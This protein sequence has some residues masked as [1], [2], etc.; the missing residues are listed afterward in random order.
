MFAQGKLPDISGEQ[1]RT[2]L[3][4]FCFVVIFGISL[5][6][7]EAAV[8]V[9]LRVIFYPGGFS[10]PL[11]GLPWSRQLLLTEVG[12]EA[13]AIILISVSA[14]LFGRNLRERFAYFLTIFAVWDIFYY[15][16]LK[17][18]INWPGSIMDW[19][20]LF[21]IPMTWASPVLAPVVV[22][23]T[24]LLF[25]LIALYR[26]SCGA[27]I[28]ITPADWLGFSAAGFVVVISFCIAGQHIT[29]SDFQSYFYWPLFAAGYITAPILFIKC[30]LKS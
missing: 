9:Y 30:L 15:V 19:D 18:L 28:R 25:A 6:Y 7:I 5:A 23:L 11:S 14:W 20:I 2:A 17:I 4:R 22:S 1:L 24:L 29:D 21:L 10:F 27:P 8:V 26:G 12:R 13:A 16:W 3:R